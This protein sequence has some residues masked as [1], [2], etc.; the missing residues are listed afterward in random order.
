MTTSSSTL[1]MR[2]GTP[3]LSEVARHV[4]VPDGVTSSQWPRVRAT[5]A[6]I[7]IRYDRWQDGLGRLILATRE[8]GI[9]AAGVGGV[10]ISIARQVGKTFLIGT[11]I[12][13]LCLLT[14]GLKVVW[15]SHH[16]ATTRATFKTIMSLCRRRRVAPHVLSMRSGNGQREIEFVNGAIIKFG[17]RGSGYARGDDAIDVIVLDEAQIL[18]EKALDDLV[19]T[20]NVSPNPLTIMLGT[21]PK[22]GDPAEVFKNRRREALAGQTRHLV[23]VEISADVDAE[24]DD[25]AQWA[26]ANPSF[27]HRTNRNAILRLRAQLGEESFRREALGIWD[28]DSAGSRLITPEQWSVTAIPRAPE[29]VKSFGVAFSEDGRRVSL[30]GARKHAKGV[31]GELIGAHTGTTERGVGP[32][33]DWLAARWRQTAVIVISGRA[34]AEPLRRALADRKVPA[35]VVHVASTG[36]YLAACA[37][38]YDDVKT[39]YFTHL[40]HSGQQRLEESVAVC[41][42]RA[43]RGGG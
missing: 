35:H 14:P 29:G 2:S 33:A 4:V 6:R 26:R 28:D 13:V 27:P 41:D 15:T 34:G 38:L 9:Y 24:P 5:A 19:P 40:D 18:T 36:D 25:E 37:Q 42:K 1:P 12:L 3:R 10:V 31:H 17:A 8:D 20:L 32:L 30:C 39:R 23:F 16:D 11:I 7:G 21:P 43:R 22:P